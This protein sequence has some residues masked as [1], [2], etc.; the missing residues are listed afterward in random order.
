MIGRAWNFLKAV[1]G[2]YFW[3]RCPRCQ[4]WFGGHE[5]PQGRMYSIEKYTGEIPYSG[6]GTCPECPNE[7]YADGEQIDWYGKHKSQAPPLQK[8]SIE[9]IQEVGPRWT[10]FSSPS[11]TT[12]EPQGFKPLLVDRDDEEA[13]ERAKDIALSVI[14]AAWALNRMMRKK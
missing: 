4:R 9:I 11:Y 3:L 14:P 7:Y 12:G 2:G 1:V 13:A 6:R 8:Q 5:E 10:T